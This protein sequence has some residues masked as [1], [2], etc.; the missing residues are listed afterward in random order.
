MDEAIVGFSITNPRSLEQQKS[1]RRSAFLT[2]STSPSNEPS[3]PSPAK[4]LTTGGSGKTGEELKAEG[5]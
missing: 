2:D 1:R 3:K 4:K 5:K